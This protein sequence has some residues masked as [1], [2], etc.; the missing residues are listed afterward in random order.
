[1]IVNKNIEKPA[2]VFGVPASE[3]VA[4]PILFMII[5]VIGIFIQSVFGIQVLGKLMFVDILLAWG[6]FLVLKWASKQKYPGFLFSILAYKFSQKR[7]IE[8]KG[9]RIK[10]KSSK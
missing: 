3:A 8:P 7:K 4:I 2:Y 6:S 5:L 9:F 1:M 10:L